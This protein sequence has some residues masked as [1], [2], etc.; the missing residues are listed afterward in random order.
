MS[1]EEEIA[2]LERILAKRRGKPG[3]TE[4][5]RDIE[6]RLAELRNG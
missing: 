1:K 6:A 2:E 3:F 4:N 5:V